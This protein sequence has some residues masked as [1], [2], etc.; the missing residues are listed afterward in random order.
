MEAAMNERRRGIMV[1]ALT[2]IQHPSEPVT[3]LP[4]MEGRILHEMEETVICRHQ[5]FI[6]WERGGCF[7]VFA[8]E[9]EVMGE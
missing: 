6:R 8:E 1:R 5:L 4:R 3:I 9:V 2:K 7:Y